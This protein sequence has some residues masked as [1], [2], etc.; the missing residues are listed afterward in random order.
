MAEYHEQTDDPSL[1][2]PVG[3]LA[4]D[5]ALFAGESGRAH[6]VLMCHKCY[7]LV[8]GIH[9]KGHE[10]WHKTLR[11]SPLDKIG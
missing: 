1:F 11:N 6:E 2:S 3:Y 10:D 4:M 9:R 7:S 8:L 5:A